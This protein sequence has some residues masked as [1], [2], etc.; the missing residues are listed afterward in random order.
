MN[1]QQR[2]SLLIYLKE[3]LDSPNFENNGKN[4]DY[5]F[6]DNERQTSI[7]KL[8]TL[9]N[10][11]FSNK[12]SLVEFKELSE[13]YCR[14]FPFWGFVGFSGQ[15]QLNQYVNNI[16][17][18]KKEV[19]IKSV[20]TIPETTDG[21]KE[22]IDLMARYLKGIK[23]SNKN[24]KSIPRINQ[25]YMLS[26]FWEIQ[27]SNKWPVYY[28]SSKKILQN[29]GF[30]LGEQGTVGEEYLVFVKIMDEIS[31]LFSSNGVNENN[32]LWFVEHVL[33]KQF[34]KTPTESGNV[35]KENVKRQR[36]SIKHKNVGI[37]DW[38]PPVIGDLEDLSRN[39]ETEWSIQNKLKP[40]KAFERKLRF[41]FTLLGY[42]VEELGQGTGRQPDGI[43]KSRGVYNGDYAIIYDAKA[44]EGKYS[45]GTGDRE[46]KEYIKNKNEELRKERIYKTCF[47][48]VSS[49]FDDNPSLD[50]LIRDLYK[51]TRVTIVLIK[52]SDLLFI[53]AAKLE[54]AEINHE[55]LENLFLEKGILT[56]EKIVEVLGLR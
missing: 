44:R 39:K 47:V 38:V 35:E 19:T 36:G 45:M 13:K 43:A 30:D 7:P 42:E 5:K 33:W 18:V 46:I 26:Y 52:A 50:D 29:I 24:P 17:D 16:D 14:D 2:S 11:Y 22:K 8:K 31:K 49:D 55:Q 51:E 21:A 12:I 54:N 27:S 10:N 37:N 25:A 6:F 15:M 53:I 9:I 48:I 40:E 32:M 20:M 3:F 4:E 56:R 28:G 1:E 41:A 23:D 34:I